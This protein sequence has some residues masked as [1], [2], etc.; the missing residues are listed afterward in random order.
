MRISDP[1]EEDR[2]RPTIRFPDPQP[3]DDWAN[4]ALKNVPPNLTYV[5]GSYA[6]RT[7]ERELW[8]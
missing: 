4:E 3:L 1:R 7:P 8:Y 5:F 6:R 2:S